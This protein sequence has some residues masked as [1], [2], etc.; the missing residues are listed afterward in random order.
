MIVHAVLKKSRRIAAKHQPSTPATVRKEQPL[1]AVLEYRV[2]MN[3]QD[4]SKLLHRDT[5]EIIKKLFLLALLQIKTKVW[6]KI[7]SKFWQLIMVSKHK[8]RRRRRC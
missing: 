1:P 5:A 6:M 7:Q 8:Q 2:G 3:V 4:L